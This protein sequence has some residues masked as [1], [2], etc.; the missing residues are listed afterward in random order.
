MA[1]SSS[2]KVGLGLM[3]K[4]LVG[5]RGIFCPIHI[6]WQFLEEF[7]DVVKHLNSY[8]P[9][10]VIIGSTQ[11]PF[12]MCTLEIPQK[13]FAAQVLALNLLLFLLLS[14]LLKLSFSQTMSFSCIFVFASSFI[15]MDLSIIQTQHS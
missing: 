12:Q 15:R 6:G 14:F 11:V 9:S 8:H 10:Q 7:C 2:S 3:R 4:R 1:V 13:L 5:C